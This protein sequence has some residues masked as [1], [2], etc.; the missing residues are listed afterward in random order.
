[1]SFENMLM[2][3]R[4]I[5]IAFSTLFLTHAITASYTFFGLKFKIAKY[6]LTM[7]LCCFLYCVGLFTF[8]FQILTGYIADLIANLQWFIAG[9]ALISYLTIISEI[10]PENR[11][12][13]SFG[14][15]VIY[16]MLC[17]FV[18][19]T[20]GF[21]ELYKF[22]AE[23]Y[24]GI[25]PV[26]LNTLMDLTTLGYIP[27]VVFAL[28]TLAMNIWTLKFFIQSKS[29]EYLIFFGIFA[30]L[31]AITNDIM[32]SIIPDFGLFPLF[33]IGTMFETIRFSKVIEEK[34][35]KQ[36]E[37]LRIKNELNEVELKEAR[38]NEILLNTLCHDI[39]NG[40]S[41]AQYGS[42]KLTALIEGNELNNEKVIKFA[43]NKISAGVDNIDN[44]RSYIMDLQK[45]KSLNKKVSME[46]FSLQESIYELISNYNDV[47]K[48][49]GIKIELSG[50]FLKEISSDRQ[51]IE[52]HIL[53]NLI[54]NAIK[55]SNSGSSVTISEFYDQNYYWVNLKNEGAHISDD[56]LKSVRAQE[57]VESRYGTKGE[58]G[59]GFGFL[60]V[61]KMLDVLQAKLKIE[62]ES[63]NYVSVSVGFKLDNK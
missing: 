47:A 3:Y 4:Y 19:D 34:T 45:A 22:R 50:D 46:D 35:R 49:K 42:T 54:S 8:S 38:F 18:F 48:A 59:H 12:V 31:L 30:T 28:N 27:A 57:V 14:I 61:M 5:L 29:K 16:S 11:K 26:F 44:I 6:Q 53:P 60:I 43:A 9:F 1:M 23:N 36:I 32:I 17:L 7:N 58:K 20:F 55:F 33:Y 63:P 56:V 51:I 37:D 24:D 39:N 62:N 40:L 52:N 41:I 21:I 15:K 2:I 13:Y 10:F 25:E